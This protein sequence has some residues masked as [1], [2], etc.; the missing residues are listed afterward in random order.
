MRNKTLDDKARDF[1]KTHPVNKIKD[2]YLAELLYYVITG[3]PIVLRR[4]A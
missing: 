2:V 3:K 4:R 1:V